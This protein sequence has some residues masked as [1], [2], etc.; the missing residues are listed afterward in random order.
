[1]FDIV[2]GM[3]RPRSWTDEQLI[4]A[5]AAS[6]TLKEVH[7]RLGLK[8]GKYDVMRAHIK[9]L[10]IDALHLPRSDVGAGSAPRRRW[11]DTDLAEAVLR[12]D[13]V[14]EVSRRLGYTPNGGV[15]RMLVARMR[16]LGLDRSH[17][18][19]MAWAK[20]QQR[21]DLALPLAEILVEGSTYGSSRL[22]ER[23]VA[24]GLLVPRCA[25]CGLTEWRGE[26]L[27]LH[28]DHI[29]GDHTDNRLTN[30]RILCPNCHSIT[31]TWCNRRGR[32]SPTGRRHGS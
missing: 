22:R 17:F 26:R 1:M 32:R 12:S 20:G 13:S 28:L 8:P 25:E 30:L 11:T 3:P 4:A 29:N 19:G 31:K 5:V 24:E 2:R 27:P 7:E 23:L 10:G 21:R 14:S 9:R 16:K 15:H 6:R 18:T